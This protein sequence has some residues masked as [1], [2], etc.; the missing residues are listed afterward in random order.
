M[1]AKNL[2]TSTGGSDP[3]PLQNSAKVETIDT[4]KMI[5]KKAE[6]S[7][8]TVSKVKKIESVASEET[9]HKI[10]VGDLSINK[11]YKEMAKQQQGARTDIC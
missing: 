11:A 2:V 4:R 8:D 5:A 3:Q 9:K 7:H 6:V 10:R 1:A